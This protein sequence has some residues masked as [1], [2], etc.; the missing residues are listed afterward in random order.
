M[1]V[2]KHRNKW[3][4]TIRHEGKH[5]YKTFTKKKDAHSYYAQNKVASDKGDFVHA[6]DD[7]T[8]A[9]AARLWLTSCEARKLER[10]TIDR[11]RQ[12]ANLHILP[13]LGAVKLNKFGL[14]ALRQWQDRLRAKG[15]TEATVKWATTALC[16]I[17][18]EAQERGLISRNVI[19]EMPRRRGTTEKRQKRKLE[20]GVDIPLP[21]E[22]SLMLMALQPKWKALISTAVFSGL[23]ASELRGLRWQDIDFENGCLRVRQRIDR[24]NEV[25]KPKSETSTRTVPLPDVLITTLKKHRLASKFSRDDQ[26]VFPNGSGHPENLS[27]IV[28]RGLHPAWIAAGI[29]DKD[30]RG[31]YSGLHC[32][33]HF[34]ASWLINSLKDGG[35]GLSAKE[36]QTRLGHSSIVM[37]M[38]V[39]SHLFPAQSVDVGFHDAAARLWTE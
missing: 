38:D 10:T 19:K 14:P 39:Y 12:H 25:G 18:S 7:L 1:S 27:N 20:S 34:H 28:R 37:T 22:V 5:S 31:R 11:Y 16:G 33:R 24:F 21:T 4:V 6:R 30:G 15:C 23:R 26:L 17:L 9:D 3:L 29:V 8:V 36:V 35:L 32:L 2:R 13:L